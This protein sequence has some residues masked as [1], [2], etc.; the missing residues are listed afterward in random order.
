MR[1]AT[2]LLA[3]LLL[4]L[5]A[6]TSAAQDQE[7]PRL[8]GH[9]VDEAEV[10]ATETEDRLIRLLSDHEAATGNQ[11]VL[12]TLSSLRGHDVSDYAR[13]LCLYWQG[14]TSEQHCG[15]LLIVV[16]A[17][18]AVRIEVAQALA[19]ALPEETRRTIVQREI[20]PFFHSEELAAGIEH[21]LR[22]ILAA[23][24]GG[25]I[26]PPDPRPEAFTRTLGVIVSFMV[27]GLYLLAL[28]YALLRRRRPTI[29]AAAPVPAGEA[30]MQAA[31]GRW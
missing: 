13:R 14:E 17:E 18:R 22:G 9:V 8:S 10:L 7:L 25:Y 15:V 4:A 16:P 2:T 28:A 3:A 5:A 6:G 21:G 20:L 12:V 24:A 31:S 26:P 23:L 27:S 1:T 29:V 11:V 19:E 30:P